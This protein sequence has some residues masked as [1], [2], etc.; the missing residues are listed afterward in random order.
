MR[1]IICLT[2][3]S[4]IVAAGPATAHAEVIVSQF[5]NFEN[6]TTQGWDSG[7]RNPHPPANVAS[8]GPAGAG[9]NYLKITS[10]DGSGAGSKLV[11]FN[12]AQWTGNYLAAGVTKITMDLENLGTSALQIRLL[13]EGD[14][15]NFVSVQSF[16]LASSSGWRVASFPLGSGDLTGGFNYSATLGH[17][18]QLRII[19]NPSANPL[20]SSVPSIVAQ[21]GVD[22][23]TAV[24]EPATLLLLAIA[25]PCLLG[26]A[27]RRYGQAR[28]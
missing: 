20:P 27:R 22:N 24:P 6:G 28:R 17:V 16:P 13:L 7:D 19:H 10:T 3:C 15:G 4:L 26:H 23:I 8:G 12:T 11:A 18:R 1:T 14:G 9:D 2:A 5:D 25:G 21:L